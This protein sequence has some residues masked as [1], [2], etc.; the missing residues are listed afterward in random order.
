MQGGYSG[1]LWYC[2]SVNN[3]NSPYSLLDHVSIDKKKSKAQKTK[4]IKERCVI[5]PNGWD[6][7]SA[8]CLSFCEE[9]EHFKELYSSGYISETESEILASKLIIFLISYWQRNAI[10][11]YNKINYLS[12]YYSR[13]VNDEYFIVY[14]YR[15]F[16]NNTNHKF[17]NSD[18]E[19]YL[20]KNAKTLVS[21]RSAIAYKKVWLLRKCLF[22]KT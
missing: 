19:N 17:W 4:Q 9:I 20:L 3:K 13:I 1:N 6:N 5:Y 2:S 7:G 14:V 21:L 12:R 22:E 18:T 16:S 15:K 11:R 10:A 8:A